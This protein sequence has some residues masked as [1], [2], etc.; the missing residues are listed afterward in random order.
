MEDLWHQ[1]KLKK[2]LRSCEGFLDINQNTMGPER[3]CSGE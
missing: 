1:M 2:S 3:F